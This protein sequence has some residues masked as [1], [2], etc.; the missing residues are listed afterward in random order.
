TRRCTRPRAKAATASASAEFL[1]GATSGA[2]VSEGFPPETVGRGYAPDI[3]HWCIAEVV[4][5]VAPTYVVR[6]AIKRYRQGDASRWVPTFGRHAC[7]P[8]PCAPP[9]QRPGSTGQR[10]PCGQPLTI[11]QNSR[12]VCSVS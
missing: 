3:P 7:N 11:W 9:G 8:P 12:A 10:P 4:G 1:F 2:D 5:A 6:S